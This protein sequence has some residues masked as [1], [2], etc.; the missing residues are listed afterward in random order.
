MGLKKDTSFTGLLKGVLKSL[1]KK[2]ADEAGGKLAETA[3]DFL[4]PIIKGSVDL[5]KEKF[6]DLLTDK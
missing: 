5:I 1:G 2:I 6:K 4:D 3:A